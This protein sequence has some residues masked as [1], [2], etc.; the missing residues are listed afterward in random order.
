VYLYGWTLAMAALAVA[1]RFVPY[2]DNHGHF[3]P[4]WTAF[5]LVL[6]VLALAASIYIVAV[7]EILKLKRLR[8]WQLR[9]LDPETTEHEI[10]AVVARDLESGE[11]DSVR[12]PAPPVPEQ[13]AG[14]AGA[15]RGT[16]E[17]D[18]HEVVSIE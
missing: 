9:R 13:A 7:L 18:E 5:M 1:L 14:G 3:H 16:G 17:T 12:L 6:I 4:G 15:A 11:L 8:A 10:A 2:S